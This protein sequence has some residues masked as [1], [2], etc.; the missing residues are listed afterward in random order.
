MPAPSLR[1]HAATERGYRYVDKQPSASCA[2]N[3]AS[4]LVALLPR[5]RLMLSVMDPRAD[6]SATSLASALHRS[7]SS[8]SRSSVC[9]YSGVDSTSADASHSSAFSRL[10]RSCVPER[11]ISA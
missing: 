2:A 1:S 9:L 5:C 8:V 11:S 7:L 4:K 6:E 10:A 3:I